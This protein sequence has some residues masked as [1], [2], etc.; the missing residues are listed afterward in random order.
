MAGYR[1]SNGGDESNKWLL[2]NQL[3]RD[4]KIGV[5]A[6]QE[7]HL[8]EKRAEEVKKLFGQRLD[9]FFSADRVNPSGAKGVA[10]VINKKAL[11]TSNCSLQEVVPGR[12]A[13][14]ELTWTAN[15]RLKILN[16]YGPNDRQENAAFWRTVK[17]AGLANVSFVLGDLN[18]VE[19]PM[20]RLPRKEDPVQA[21]DSLHDLMMSLRV[22][23]G[24][25]TA[26][27]TTYAFTYLQQATGSQ[28]RIDRIYVARSMDKDVDDWMICETGIPTDHKMVSVMVANKQAPFVGKGRWSMPT[29][30][31]NDDALK[32]E[33]KR[34]GR[35]LADEIASIGERSAAHNAQTLYNVFK[36][37]LIDAARSRAKTPRG[38]TQ[39]AQPG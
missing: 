11:Q 13:L 16:V 1:L 17:L 8:D 21:Q 34:L 28:S 26:N 10:F 35:R 4:N 38:P 20:D 2:V 33:M 25:R 36:D 3:M 22:T 19:S 39:F 29:H 18:V 5:L 24:W 31:L 30:L 23:D 12:A 14:L 7:A 27:P 6:V 37:D 15:R 9:L 32:D